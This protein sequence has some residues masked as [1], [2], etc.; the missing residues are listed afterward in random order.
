MGTLCVADYTPRVLSPRERQWLEALA[1][2]VEDELQ[3]ATG[4]TGRAPDD[5]R[6]PGGFRAR[7]A[8]LFDFCRRMQLPCGL[9]VARI[10]D[11]GG[12]NHVH[13]RAKG[14]HLLD[15]LQQMVTETALSGDLAG[16]MRGREMALLIVNADEAALQR[17]RAALVAAIDAH[18]RQHPDDPRL[19]CALGEAIMVPGRA[20]VFEDL[21]AQA[22]QKASPH[23]APT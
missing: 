5:P 19:N 12:I 20:D 11:M 10:R 23:D 7:A 15:T 16:R 18:N 1:G 17:S 14:D 3:R 8:W 9:L 21:V 22:H 4:D 2:L 6:Q 13:G